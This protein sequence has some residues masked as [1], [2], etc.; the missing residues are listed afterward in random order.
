M[1]IGSAFLVFG[2]GALCV[3]VCRLAV[4]ALPAFAGCTAGF[5]AY[6][7]GAGPIGAIIVA[8]VAG[9]TTVAA[10][11]LVFDATRNGAV[12]VLVALLFAAP[13]AL[14]GYHA[15]LGLA[16]LIVPSDA[17][18]H[19]FATIGALVIGLTAVVRLAG[20]DRL[21][22]KAAPQMLKLGEFG[23]VIRDQVG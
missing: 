12:R 13:A 17:W 8:L 3:L 7:T 6:D 14:A 4:D 21:A 22:T 15:V 23:R 2:I 11:R 20:S 9:A 19:A 10:G 18:Q 16:H 1:F 5:W